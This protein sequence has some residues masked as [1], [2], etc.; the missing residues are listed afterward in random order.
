MPLR[1]STWIGRW[2]VA[3]L[4][5]LA[6]LACL[7]QTGPVQAVT[8]RDART[9]T[10][11]VMAHPDDEFEAWSLI[12]HRP[13]A[14]TVFITA[15]RGEETRFCNAPT[16]N[17]L[18]F[19]PPS[20]LAPQPEPHGKWTR[21]CELARLGSWVGFFTDM[22]RTDAS[23]PSDLRPLGT[24]GP[25]PSRGAA[26]CRYD[27]LARCKHDRT[28]RVWLDR[29]G[30]GA[31]VAFDLGDG[32]LTTREAIW[33]VRTVKMYRARLG[34]DTTL[35]NGSLIAAAFYNENFGCVTYSS[36]DHLAVQRAVRDGSFHMGPRLGPTCRDDPQAVRKPVVSRRAANTA[37]AEGG[38][39][40]RVGAHIRR[41]GW[42]KKTHFP[43]DRAGQGALFHTHQAFWMR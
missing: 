30:R 38:P 41:Y 6:A 4:A 16:Y 11:V 7:V 13:G 22:G 29:G 21:S 35:R 42:L 18:G 20:E 8:A 31:L 36:A 27:G 34:L 19:D 2:R 15:T 3:A 12:E 17:R 43:L 24:R 9:M 28:A 37:F 32:D 1:S 39:V 5:G 40:R 26:L 25:F 10:Y 23:L 14:Y 33:A